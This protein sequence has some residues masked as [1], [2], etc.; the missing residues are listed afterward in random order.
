MMIAA[1]AASVALMAQSSLVSRR[2]RHSTQS[3]ID[4]SQVAASVLNAVA[5][6]TTEGIRVMAAS[7]GAGA[8]LGK[9]TAS[10]AWLANWEIPGAV[11]NIQLRFSA[12]RV[13]ASPT[14]TMSP[15]PYPTASPSP[16]WTPEPSHRVDLQLEFSR[17]GG[18][19]WQTLTSSKW[20]A[21]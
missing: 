18:T 16:A 4:S 1:V 19:T 15:L 12:F 11:R 9:T 8:W 14:P 2:A 7:G 6:T 3:R 10:L 13:L 17:D 21:R 5:T 20:V